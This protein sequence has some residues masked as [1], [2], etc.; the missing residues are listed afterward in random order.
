MLG[1]SETGRSESGWKIHCSTS[2]VWNISQKAKK[3]LCWVPCKNTFL[4]I[5][6][7]RG[8]EGVY[9]WA[10]RQKCN[11]LLLQFTNCKTCNNLFYFFLSGD[12]IDM[13]KVGSI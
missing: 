2:I 1:S 10:K 6:D 11:N 5:M 8:R 3:E 12:I 13:M 9:F 4:S 7:G